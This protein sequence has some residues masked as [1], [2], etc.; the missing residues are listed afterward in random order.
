VRATDGTR[1]DYV[2]V[3]WGAVSG[4]TQYDVYRSDTYRGK[5][6]FLGSTASGYREY[7]DWATLDGVTYHYW[8]ASCDAG[9]CSSDLEEYGY[10]SGYRV[11]APDVPGNIQA[12]DGTRVG[13]VEVTWNAVQDAYEYEV[14]R[15]DTDP[16]PK[17]RLGA[18]RTTSYWDASGLA[19]ETYHYSVKACLDP[20][21]TN[22]CSD[23]GDSDA[24]HYMTVPSPPTGL[25]ASDGLYE[26][27]VRV[28][29]NASGGNT[30]YYRVYRGDSAGGPEDDLGTTTGQ[31]FDDL[32][33]Q[34]FYPDH[35]HA[36][37]YWVRACTATDLCSSLSGQDR[38]HLGGPLPPP[39]SWVDASDG[40]E[41]GVVQVM[42]EDVDDATSYWVYRASSPGGAKVLIAD[43]YVPV[44]WYVDEDVEPGDVFYY[45]IKSHNVQGLSGTFSPGD[46]GRPGVPPDTPGN[47]QAS[48]D[49][50]NDRV[51]VTWDP[52]EVEPGWVSFHYMVYRSETEGGVKTLLG[53]T[54]YEDPLDTTYDD[55]S[56]ASGVTYH[57]WVMAVNFH[58][59]SDYGGP[60]TGRRA[61]APGPTST[62][63][64]TPT[65]G[66]SA[67]VTNT[68]LVPHL[69]GKDLYLPLIMR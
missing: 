52:V 22:C 6:T 60:D 7:H 1:C 57:Y 44:L 17:T 23:L 3:D 19:D 55:Y 65:S 63:S 14:W 39:P 53:Y 28:T 56:A 2:L 43:F 33:M 25:A 29:W 8:V 42:W 15:S 37:Y 4:A 61:G 12:T 68:P 50:Y 64:A 26:D 34:G 36:Y 20:G 58:G 67:T 10:D 45:Y 32:P 46:G 54:T 49:A 48:D 41:T 9:G 27:K 51:R 5:K 59:E 47:V 69:M 18:S 11:D 31:L 38:G 16:G 24:G 13:G 62:A 35:I 66:P 30:A 21:A 40:T